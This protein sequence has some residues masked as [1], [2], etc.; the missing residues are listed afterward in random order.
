MVVTGRFRPCMWR[1]WRLRHL[2][3]R[4]LADSRSATCY[5]IEAATPPAPPAVSLPSEL[6]L[7]MPR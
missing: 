1:R 4:R 2:R 5:S 7:G 3:R 6:C